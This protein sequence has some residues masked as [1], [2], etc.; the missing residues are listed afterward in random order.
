MR[1]IEK[2]QGVSMIEMSI[3]GHKAGL[4]I[5]KS[6]DTIRQLQVGACLQVCR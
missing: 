2:G 1:I 3:P 4:L 5:G 6:G